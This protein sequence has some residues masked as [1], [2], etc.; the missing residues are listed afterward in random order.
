MP[1]APAQGPNYEQQLDL[2]GRV[3]D[4]YRF[5]VQLN[6]DRVKYL[7]AYNTAVFTAGVGLVKLGGPFGRALVIGVFAIGIVGCALTAAAARTQHQYYATIRNQMT[8]L[9]ARLSLG[10]AAIAT[11]PGA[12]GM[13]RTWV[14]KLARVQTLIYAV[15]VVTGV[16]DI[17]GAIYVIVRG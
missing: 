4:E 6:W 2:Y 9:S 3:V 13:P 17:L 15:L 14:Q 7:I 12:R 8:T 16:A 10:D 11:T 1:P 5:Q